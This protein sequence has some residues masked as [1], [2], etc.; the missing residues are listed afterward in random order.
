VFRIRNAFLRIR[1]RGS[2][3]LKYGFGS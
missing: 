1:I 3:I 2:V